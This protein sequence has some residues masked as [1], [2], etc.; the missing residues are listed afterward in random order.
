MESKQL[1]V[2]RTPEQADRQKIDEIL[3]SRE[4]AA[5]IKMSEQTLAIWRCTKRYDNDLP[6][7]KVGRSVRYLRSDVE[8]FLARH[9]VGGAAEE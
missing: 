2:D 3:T 5:L 7:H 1:S 9:R 6:Y 8:A 4:T